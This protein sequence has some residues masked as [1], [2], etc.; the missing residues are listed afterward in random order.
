MTFF[1]IQHKINFCAY[2]PKIFHNLLIWQLTIKSDWSEKIAQVVSFP[3]ICP[4]QLIGFTVWP[5]EG[6]KVKL[7]D[8][9]CFLHSFWDI[10]RKLKI[11]FH[12]FGTPCT[13]PLSLDTLTSILFQL[14]RFWGWRGNYVNFDSFQCVAC[15]KNDIFT[16][17]W[18]EMSFLCHK[19][20]GI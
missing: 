3:K 19:P 14:S 13:Q 16:N 2:F 4:F 8:N 6:V 20:E 7:F 15:L 17:E 12:F 18:N 5:L 9:F 1:C 11:V 10:F